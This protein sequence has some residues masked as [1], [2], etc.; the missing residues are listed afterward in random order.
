[1]GP[2][3]QSCNTMLNF[4]KICCKDIAIFSIF[5][6]GGR[7]PSWNCMGHAWTTHKRHLVV[8]I[9]VQNLVAIN[10]VVSKI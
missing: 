7:P 9:A 6:D 5:Q 3:G 2:G 1:M 4:V 10:A 8:F